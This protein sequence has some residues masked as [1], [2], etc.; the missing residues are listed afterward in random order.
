ME[1]QS[2][3]IFE[4]VF[5]LAPKLVE[6]VPIAVKDVTSVELFIKDIKLWTTDKCSCLS[7]LIQFHFLLSLK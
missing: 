6:L 2:F 3:G 4:T 7:V 1:M 5:S